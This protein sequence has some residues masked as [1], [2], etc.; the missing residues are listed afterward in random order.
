MPSA[1]LELA[2]KPGIVLGFWDSWLLSSYQSD[3][4]PAK[5]GLGSYSGRRTWRH[6]GHTDLG[7]D[8]W[9]TTCG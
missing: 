3:D 5:G 1:F 2:K 7:S 4:W 8:L 9:P 6:R